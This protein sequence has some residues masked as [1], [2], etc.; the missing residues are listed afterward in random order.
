VG[1]DRTHRPHLP[2]R[3][4][5]IRSRGLLREAFGFRTLYEGDIDGYPLLH[6]G[7]GGLT[8]PGLWIHPATDG[9]PVGRQTGDSPFLVLYLDDAAELDAVLERCA[10]LGGGTGEP[11]R[12][13]DETAER[14]AHVRDLDGNGIVLALLAR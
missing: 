10:R 14:Y 1:H 7:P 2:P 13:S 9:A 11:L 5:P 12:E 4:R 8:D 6:V 3:P